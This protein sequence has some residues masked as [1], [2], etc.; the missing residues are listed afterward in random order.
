MSAHAGRRH[1]EI[2]GAGFAGLAAATALAQHGWS[3][4]VHERADRLRTTGAGIYLYENGLRVLEALG[5][6]ANAVRDAPL[7]HTRETRDQDDRVLAVH[8]WGDT[9]RVFSILRQQVIDA[10]A[11]AARRAGA[12][13]VTNS[14]AVAATPEGVL[15]LADGRRLEA[16]LIIA[17]DGANSRLRDELHL[18][19]KRR[20]L[21]DGAIR[22][23]LDKTPEEM[24]STEGGRTIE[25]WSG[26]RRI[27]YTPCG[28]TQTYLALTMLDRDADAKSV[29][30]NQALWKAAFPHLGPLIARI[31]TQGRYDRFEVITLKRWSSG[32]V[33]VIGDAAHA[34]PPNIGQGAGCAMMNA[35]ALA[36]HLDRTSDMTSA[37]EAWERDE[38]SL[39]EHTQRISV[40][41]GLPTTWPAFLRRAF[42]SLAGRS[43]WLT[44][45]RTRTALHKPLGTAP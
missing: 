43:K 37:L 5:A 29:P 24:R 8:R 28:P 40:F 23:L 20:F 17:A 16:D 25:Y 19:S 35:L 27:L 1:A 26:S 38:R 14:Q 34:L 3:V 7:A 36:I 39:T 6:Y 42:F 9:G 13:I 10:L 15:V 18:L 32:K 11:A 45:Q 2:A 21:P 33:A 30:I 22:L 44:R 4:R 12:E 31:G 41:L